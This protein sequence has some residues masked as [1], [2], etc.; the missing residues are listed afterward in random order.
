M[1]AL[2]FTEKKKRPKEGTHPS[3]YSGLK[4]SLQTCPWDHVVHSRLAP[5]YR[6]E[7][8]TKEEIGFLGTGHI[9]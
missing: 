3:G 6:W 2:A 8:E 1:T 5:S 4:Q 9:K 7:K